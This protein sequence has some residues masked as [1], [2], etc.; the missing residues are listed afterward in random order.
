MAAGE[1]QGQPLVG[2]LGQVGVGAGDVALQAL[3][4][5]DVGGLGRARRAAAQ[6]IEGPPARCSHDP[7]GG[8]AGHTLGGPALERSGK[9]VLQRFLGEVEVAEVAD[10]AREHGA[11]FLADHGLHRVARL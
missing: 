2:D 10:E 1:D 5:R 6:P 11:V 7:G 3:E 4:Q 9:G 8:V